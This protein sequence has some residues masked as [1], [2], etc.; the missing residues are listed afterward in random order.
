MAIDSAMVLINYF[1]SHVFI[2]VVRGITDAVPKLISGI[3][4]FFIAYFGIKI[5]LSVAETALSH[6]LD[7]KSIINLKL[8]V[9]GAFLWFSAILM[10]LTILGMGDIAASLGTA[11]GFIG[12]GV[13]YALKDMI[14][15]T[16]A[17]VYLLR[18]KDFN[19]G[20]QVESNGVEGKV[21][22]IDLRK[23]RFE[24][25]NGDTTVVANKEVEKK[26]TKKKSE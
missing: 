16:V 11:A 25:E 10:L 2:P 9:I 1:S 22:D 23:T 7:N 18:D 4:F 12:L 17:G 6:K 19:P 14:A 15:D 3:I 20:D 13:A 5:A 26:W 24:L 8:T 21:K